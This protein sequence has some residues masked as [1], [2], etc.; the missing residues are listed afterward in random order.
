MALNTKPPI[1]KDGDGDGDDTLDELPITVFIRNGSV[2][3]VQY[4]NVPVRALVCDYDVEFPCVA[5]G[6]NKD[7][8]GE[9]YMEIIV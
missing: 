4:N 2:T 3:E 5:H 6:L 9:Y 1:T 8:D 7:A